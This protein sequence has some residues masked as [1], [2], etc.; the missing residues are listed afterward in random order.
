MIL[1]KL[2]A[3]FRRA[4][5]DLRAGLLADL[6]LAARKS[7]HPAWLYAL[8]DMGRLP[9]GEKAE[10]RRQFAAVYD[11]RPL[12]NVP[13]YEVL[14][15]HGPVLVSHT[16]G[17]SSPTLTLGN[18]AHMLAS[19]PDAISAWLVSTVEPAPLARHFAQASVAV[20]AS[21]K[22]Y[23]L[24]WSDPL[25]LPVV[26]KMADRAWVQW[27]FGPLASWWYPTATKEGEA[28]R[29]LEGGR[30]DAPAAP[31]QL[32]MTEELLEAMASDPFP[33]QLVSYLEQRDATVFESHCYGVR[34]AQAEE[35]IAA[36]RSKGLS[37]QAD[38]TTYVMALLKEPGLSREPDWQL[39]MANAASGKMPLRAYFGV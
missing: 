21:G 6:Q 24:R 35:I 30:Q 10:R 20:D 13:G 14:T 17:A 15:P 26:H 38:L 34:V 28:W 9:D 29:R 16:L 8:I 27:L 36:G 3:P 23:L 32:V 7:G 31:V 12:L 4:Q 39:A 25:I 19:K 33:Y 22:R 11:A 2:L 18:M 1:D 37:S 5:P